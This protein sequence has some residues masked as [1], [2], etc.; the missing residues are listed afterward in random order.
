MIT[1]KTKWNDENY[2]SENFKEIMYDKITAGIDLTE[3][4]LKGLACEFPFYEIEK[5]RDSFTVD[6]QS[7]VKLRDKYFAINWQQGLEDFE[8]SKFGAQPYEVNK[9]NRMTTKINVLCT[10]KIPPQLRSGISYTKLHRFQ[11]K[12]IYVQIYYS[13][14]R[15]NMEEIIKSE[16]ED[17]YRVTDG[18]TLHVKK[19]GKVRDEET[20]RYRCVKLEDLE[21]L[22]SYIKGKN[23]RNCRLKSASE[24]VYI[25]NGFWSGDYTL[26]P[27]G[28]VFDNYFIV[29]PVSPN[30]Y[31][32][33]IKAT[34]NSFSGNVIQ[35]NKMVKD[36]ME[37]VNHEVY[38]DIFTQLNKIGVCN[39]EGA[40]EENRSERS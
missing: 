30:L 12:L 21:K 37:V 28:S 14:E 8:D 4:E 15:R 26:V 1:D 29:K 38:E 22:K 33:E 32:Y 36:I 27:K 31:R 11:T 18:V 3:S 13:T 23:Y 7:I 20:G 10:K 5:D 6:T 19:Y 24:D 25:D 2:Y 35:I 17:V 34:G 16:Y 40:N 39:V 9:V